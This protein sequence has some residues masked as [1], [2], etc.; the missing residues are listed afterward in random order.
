ML[1]RFILLKSIEQGLLEKV[2]NFLGVSSDFDAHRLEGFDLIG[3]Q[4]RT[5]LDN[6][7]SMSH[8]LSWRRSLSGYERHYWLG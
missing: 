7:P 8:P 5:A 4:T 1:S 6:C 3:R 2:G